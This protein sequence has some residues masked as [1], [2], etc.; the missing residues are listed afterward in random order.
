MQEQISG[1]SLEQGGTGIPESV[2]RLNE[3]MPG[4]SLHRVKVRCLAVF[5]PLKATLENS[6][7]S[8]YHLSMLFSSLK[9][10]AGNWVRGILH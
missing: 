3:D 7:G 1:N 6:T 2:K 10:K 8:G 4:K 5:H 9:N